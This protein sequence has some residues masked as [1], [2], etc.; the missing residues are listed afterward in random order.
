MNPK[1]IFKY[2][3]QNKIGEFVSLFYIGWAW[4]LESIGNYPQ[5]HKIYLKATQK[6]VVVVVTVHP[7]NGALTHN[8]SIVAG[9]QSLRTCLRENTRSFNGA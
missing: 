4:V 9:K 6:Y 1:D 5:A 3:Y 7:E 8:T 2:L